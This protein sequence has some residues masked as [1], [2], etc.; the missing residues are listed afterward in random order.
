MSQPPYNEQP[1]NYGV[2]VAL[3]APMVVGGQ[4][5]GLLS[6][7]YGGLEHT[8]TQEEIALAKAVAKLA[9]LVI[10]R[11]RLLYEP[12]EAPANEL[13]LREFPQR[14]NEVFRMASHEIKT[15]LT[16]IK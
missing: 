6:L 3:V 1:N 2:R 11:V 12:A 14:L 9:G 15:P 16:T 10:E 7:D 4:L 8:Y 13:A 5:V